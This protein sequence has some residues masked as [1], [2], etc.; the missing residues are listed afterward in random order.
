MRPRQEGLGYWL[1]SSPANAGFRVRFGARIGSWLNV[2][3]FTSEISELLPLLAPGVKTEPVVWDF[4]IVSDGLGCFDPGMHRVSLSGHPAILLAAV[5]NLPEVTDI[6]FSQFGTECVVRENHFLPM[7]GVKD[8]FGSGLPKFARVHGP[9]LLNRVPC[10]M[11]ISGARLPEAAGVKVFARDLSPKPHVRSSLDL[12]ALSVPLVEVLTQEA[13]LAK[14]W[15]HGQAELL[16]VFPRIPV[17]LLSRVR[18]F[19]DR[20]QLIYTLHGTEKVTRTRIHDLCAVRERKSGTV[21]LVPRRSKY[22][23]VGLGA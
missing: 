9:A 11:G 21:H 1:N 8:G 12:A 2:P 22:E 19:Q 5:G 13:E 7:P 6:E 15:E 23:V 10:V 20:K 17:E 14:H 3:A 16:A 4:P 18:Y